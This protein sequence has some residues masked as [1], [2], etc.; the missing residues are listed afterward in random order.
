[1]AGHPAGP[2]TNQGAGWPCLDHTT[3]SSQDFQT[4]TLPV[5][6]VEGRHALFLV[7]PEMRDGALRYFCFLA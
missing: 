3:L 7:F 2:F 4:Y 1:M 6:P 5:R